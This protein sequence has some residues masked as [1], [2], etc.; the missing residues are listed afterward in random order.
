MFVLFNFRLVQLEKKLVAI[1]KFLFKGGR[2]GEGKVVI[3]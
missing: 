1:S 3:G 2:G